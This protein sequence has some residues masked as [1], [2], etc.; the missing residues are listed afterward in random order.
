[1]FILFSILIT[2][3]VLIGFAL[4]GLWILAIVQIIQRKDLQNDKW[5]W[6]IILLFGGLPGLVI[7]FFL[8]K[9][10]QLGLW[11]LVLFIMWMALIV[12]ALGAA[13]FSG[14]TQ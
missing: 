10:K 11:S 13:I 4:F 8:E 5:L 9:R 2:L 7:Y 14:P 6:I 3:V 12:T 1:M